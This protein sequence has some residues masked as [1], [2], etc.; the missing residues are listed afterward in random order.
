MCN[1][2]RLEVEFASIM[3]DFDDLEINIETPEGALDDNPRADIR[4]TETAPIV[5]AVERPPGN[6]RAVGELVNR[7]WSR[8][9]KKG[10]IYNLRSEGFGGKPPNL[11]INRCLVLC[12]GFYE[13]TD[14]P[15]PRPKDKWL[16][17]WLFEMKDHRWFCMTGIWQ[18]DAKVGEAFSLLTMDTGDDIKPYHHRQIIPLARD[19]W[20]DWLNP[21]VPAEGNLIYLPAG[22]LQVTQVYPPLT[23]GPDQATFAL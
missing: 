10:P 22:M 20:A 6:Y 4:I 12:D 2:Y 5:R 15:A 3:E 7:R 11:S 9:G 13:F 23:P 14:P 1:D 18:H 19:Q 17:K 8:P 16:D 21:D